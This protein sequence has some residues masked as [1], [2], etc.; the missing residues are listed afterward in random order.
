MQVHDTEHISNQELGTVFND[1]VPGGNNL[2]TAD[3]NLV[4]IVDNT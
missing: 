4:A 2:A 1:A 3:N